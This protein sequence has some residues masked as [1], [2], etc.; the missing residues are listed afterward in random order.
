MKDLRERERESEAICTHAHAC[1]EAK[2]EHP[3]AKGDT[4][5]EILVGTEQAIQLCEGNCLNSRYGSVP[6]TGI[7][8]V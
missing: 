7:R 3:V 5:S 8:A 2:K 6:T 4:F 1:T